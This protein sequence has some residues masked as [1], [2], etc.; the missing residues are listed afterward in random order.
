M[1]FIRILILGIVS[2]F[3]AF[4]IVPSSQA[5]DAVVGGACTDTEFNTALNTVQSTGGGTITFNC[6][7]SPVIITV[8]GAKPISSQTTIDGGSLITLSGANASRVFLVNPGISLTLNNLTVTKGLSSSDDGG[9]IRNEGTLNINNCKFINN[10]TGSAWSGGAI[11]SYGPLNIA[12][13]EFA[14]NSAGNGGALY[15]R[16]APAVTTITRSTFHDNVAINTTDGWG[17][18]ILA[19]DGAPVTIEGSDIFNN[20]SANFGGVSTSPP[21]R[22]SLSTEAR[23]TT[24]RP[25]SPAVVSTTTTAR[26]P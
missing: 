22:R 12:D 2:L 10:Q 4:I 14:N 18:A 19:W 25:D 13:S 20:S 23:F 16:Y 11:V 9:A 26:R 7:T 21:I 8:T 17:G 24:T 6:G 3:P 5:V 15:P 1:K